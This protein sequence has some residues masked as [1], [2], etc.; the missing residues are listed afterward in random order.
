MGNKSFVH[1][2]VFFIFLTV[3]S[4][5]PQGEQMEVVPPAQA[6]EAVAVPIKVS[7]PAKSEPGEVSEPSPNPQEPTPTMEASQDAVVSAQAFMDWYIGYMEDNQSQDGEIFYPFEDGLHKQVDLLTEAYIA[8]IDEILAIPVLDRGLFDPLMHKWGFLK[9]YS[10]EQV[11]VDEKVSTIAVQFTGPDLPS[12]AG[13]TL[14]LIKTGTGWKINNIRPENIV[15]PAGVTILFFDWYL[16]YYREGGNPLQDGAYQASEYLS[17]SFVQRVGEGQEGSSTGGLDPF[18][19]SWEIPMGGSILEEPVIRGD[20]ASVNLWRYFYSSQSQPLVVHL[21]RSNGTWVIVDTALEEAPLNPTEV[22]EAFYGWYLEYTK[23]D[24]DGNFRNALVDRAYQGSPYLAESF[25]AKLDQREQGYD[26]ILCAQDIPTS[27]IPDGFF[28][29]K[30]FP[31]G[32]AKNASVVVRTSFPGHIFTIDLSRPGGSGDEWKIVDVICTF[33]PEGTVKTFYTWYQGCLEGSTDCR[34]PHAGKSYPGTGLVTEQFVEQVEALREEFAKSGGGGYD[35][36]MLAQEQ[37]YAFDV[38]KVY[39]A[40]SSEP[41]ASKARV[42]LR[43]LSMGDQGD[44]RQGLLVTLVDAGPYWKIDNVTAYFENTPELTAGKFYSWY[45]NLLRSGRNPQVEY[46]FEPE[47]FL[48]ADY[49]REVESA[50]ESHTME[51]HNPILFTRQLPE[52]IKVAQVQEE[53]GR[54]NVVV[55]RYFEGQPSPT[56]MVVSMEKINGWWV[57]VGAEEK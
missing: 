21:E 32:E 54:A 33:S 14:D 20:R 46:G 34:T 35:P 53:A 40:N 24:S 30:L 37:Y 11:S 25:K 31:P 43:N 50:L 57:I 48:S 12:W 5:T 26:P 56:S 44:G 41:G 9:D 15:S 28:V 8:R 10:L 36:I 42:F 18:V 4:C 52:E 7:E 55:E 29:E 45:I 49:L 6:G 19:L 2:F 3:A 23:T 38:V 39:Q 13:A 16:G 51:G 47:A 22:V 27:V 17:A 1:W